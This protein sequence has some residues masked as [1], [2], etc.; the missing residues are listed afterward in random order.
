MSELLNI[1]LV[2]GKHVIVDVRTKERFI[3]DEHSCMNALVEL[4][5]ERASIDFTQEERKRIE[6]EVIEALITDKLGGLFGGL[7]RGKMISI[8]MDGEMD[9]DEDS[10]WFTEEQLEQPIK[11]LGPFYTLDGCL[12]MKALPAAALEYVRLVKRLD[13]EGYKGLTDEDMEKAAA[14]NVAYQVGMGMVPENK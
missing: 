5:K 4:F 9:E 12:H 1:D 11:T 8:N 6:R 13:R 3:R 7:G 10:P 14:V 2:I